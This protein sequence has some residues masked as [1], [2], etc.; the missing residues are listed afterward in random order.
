[1]LDEFSSLIPR[2]YGTT[3]I[4]QEVFSQLPFQRCGFSYPSFAR[5]TN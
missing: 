3:I 4:F 5:F 1:L 2:E